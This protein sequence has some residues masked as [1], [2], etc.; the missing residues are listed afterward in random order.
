MNNKKYCYACGKQIDICAEICP[1]CGMR[2]ESTNVYKKNKITAGLL[3]LF[4]GGIGIHRFYIGDSTKGILY[5][6]FFWTFIPGII[7]LIDAIR[8]FIMSEKEFQD[9]VKN[10]QK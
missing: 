8:I 2:Q 7:A 6:I 5:L 10:F 1:K 4:L 3:A 9:Y